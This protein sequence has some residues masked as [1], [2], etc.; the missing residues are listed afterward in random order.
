MQ[1]FYKSMIWKYA[2]IHMMQEHDMENSEKLA[3][4]WFKWNKQSRQ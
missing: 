3:R 1:I 2:N 4:C